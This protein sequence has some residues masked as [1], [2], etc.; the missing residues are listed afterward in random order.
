MNKISVC[1][2]HL[3]DRKILFAKRKVDN[4]QMSGRWELIGGKV[5]TEDTC[6]KTALKRE[7]IEE[8]GVDIDVLNYLSWSSFVNKGKR[9]KLLAYKINLTDKIQ[10]FKALE[11]D[12][13]AYFDVNKIKN[14]SLVDSDK[15]VFY[16]V[17]KMNVF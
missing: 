9:R 1:G 3:I 4:T 12:D 8:I 15:D 7:F 16:K 6:Y 11:H 17:L 10:D 2:I 14:L 13:F 5:D